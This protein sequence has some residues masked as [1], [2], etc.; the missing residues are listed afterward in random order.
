M[1][2]HPIFIHS[3]LSTDIGFF[4][5]MENPS[6]KGPTYEMDLAFDDMHGQFKA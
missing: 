1:T 5:L 3:F 6:L 4:L 2:Q